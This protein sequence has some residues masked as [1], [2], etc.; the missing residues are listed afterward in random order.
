MFGRLNKAGHRTTSGRRLRKN[1][2]RALP[3]ILLASCL[4]KLTERRAG[5][6]LSSRMGIQ[7]PVC[8]VTRNGCGTENSAVQLTFAG[9]QGRP[10]F[11]NTVR[12]H[13][14]YAV[15]PWKRRRGYATRALKLLL[16]QARREGLPYVDI[17]ADTDNIPSQRVIEANGGKLVERFHK[18]AEFGGAES[19]RFRIHLSSN[20]N[21]A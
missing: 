1:N 14:G 5:L 18:S 11:L 16:P 7:L 15:V 10:N 3:K 12:G 8:L 6:R 2:S 20:S 19:F 4:N 13:I 9:N 21:S 17:V